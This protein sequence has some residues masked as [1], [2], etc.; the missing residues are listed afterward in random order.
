MRRSMLQKSV[1]VMA[2][3][4]LLTT[5]LTG[6]G[7]GSQQ[8]DTVQS[9]TEEGQ[10]AE[11][12]GANR[13]DSSD[14][15]KFASPKDVTFPLKEKLT[16]TV[17]VNNPDQGVTSYKDNWVTDWIEEQTN[18]HLDYIY[19][20]TGDEA[21]QKLN[22]IMTDP[23]SMPDFFL[24][25]GWSK[26]ETLSYGTQ[27]LIIPLEDMLS[28]MDNWNK[29]NE[30]S[31]MRKADLTMG[32]G[33]I[34]T[35]GGQNECFHCMYQHRM[36]IYKPWVEK[37]LGGKNPETTEELYEFLKKVK[38]DDANGNGI[39]DEV[40]MTGFIG[41]WASDPTV[42]MMNSFTQCVNPISNTNP[43]VAGGLVVNNGKIEYAVMK[44]EYRE[45]LRYM[46]KLFKEGLLDNQTFL[47]DNTQ[48]SATM[49]PT[50]GNKVAVYANG[51]VE[52][53]E[54]WQQVDGEWQNWEILAPVAGPDG[55]RYSGR[56]IQT[57]FEG[58]LGTI[59]STCK[60]PEV[61]V[62]LFDWMTSEDAVHHIGGGPEGIGWN[63]TSEG[64]SLSGGTPTYEQYAIPEDYDYVKD[65]GLSKTYA[66]YRYTP[67]AMLQRGS[68]EYRG[69]LR[70]EDPDHS[71]EYFFQQC[72]EVYDKYSPPIETLVPNMSFE[73]DDARVVTES[74]LTIGGYVNQALVQFIDGSMDIEKDWDSYIEK[75]RSMGVDEYIA[76][77]QRAYDAYMEAA[78]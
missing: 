35:Y 42:W 59:S 33:H 37:Y 70:V 29:M 57:Y 53:S 50:E 32:D 64:V 78:K 39:A 12:A 63:Y 1:A 25:T 66:N 2:T 16:L 38:E 52:N 49:D 61:V 71:T 28:Q 62:A 65:G 54:F 10:G 69:N 43:T 48:F 51:G 75:L 76:A 60:Y 7:S 72:A 3:L 44:D 58:C 6:C 31:P 8:G 26:A 73:E 19:D 34:Y 5:S 46:H 13:D 55:V 45:G 24:R 40:P 68:A 17:F 27:G 11:V 36:Y 67:D 15:F 9:G 14:P 4:T 41:G 23:D 56:C 30:E 22:L 21:T 20:L 47:Q 74:T 18:I 77:Y